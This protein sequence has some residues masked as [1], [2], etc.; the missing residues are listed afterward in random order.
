MWVDANGRAQAKANL[1][2]MEVSVFEEVAEDPGR[3]A[4]WTLGG[5]GAGA[6]IGAKIGTMI[7]PGAGTA[8]GA[9]IGALSGGLLGQVLGT[10]FKSDY[11]E[12]LATRFARN[13]ELAGKALAQAAKLDKQADKQ[14]MGMAEWVFA[15]DD[16]EKRTRDAAKMLRDAVTKAEA[17]RAADPDAFKRAGL[18]MGGTF[19]GLSDIR[20]QAQAAVFQPGGELGAANRAKELENNQKAMEPLVNEVKGLRQDLKQNGVQVPL[21][22]N[23]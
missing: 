15:N 21:N 10:K 5:A 3:A 2:G 17:M 18:G 4:I 1:S 13:P 19:S 16:P 6:G 22:A 14:K 8:I 12:D 7:A 9:G 23:P 20:M 11:T